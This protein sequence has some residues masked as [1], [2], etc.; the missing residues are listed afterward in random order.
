MKWLDDNNPRVK[1]ATNEVN[2][3]YKGNVFKNQYLT[4]LG[5]RLPT[6]Q[7]QTYSI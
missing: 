1:M 2:A 3:N 4:I 7:V 5:F 6:G